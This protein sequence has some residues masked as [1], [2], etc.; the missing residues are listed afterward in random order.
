MK[1]GALIVGLIALASTVLLAIVH[2]GDRYFVLTTSGVWMGLAD[3]ARHGLIF[4]ADH[5]G[6][7]FAGTRY[8]PLPVLLHAGL[9]SLT[10]EYLTS[11]KLL[12]LLSLAVLCLLV[13]A[14]FRRSGLGLALT[15]GLLGAILVGTSRVHR[16]IVHQTRSGLGDT[17]AGRA[18]RGERRIRTPDD[19]FAGGPVLARV[20]GKAQCGLPDTR[21]R[22]LASDPGPPTPDRLR[23]CPRRL[24]GR[25][26]GVVHA[27]ER[28]THVH[29]ESDPARRRRDRGRAGCDG[30]DPTSS[31]ARRART[32]HVPVVAVRD[33]RDRTQRRGPNDGCVRVRAPVRDGHP[34]F[35]DGR[36]WL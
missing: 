23:R 33:R 5:G 28:R 29:E 35:P 21:D 3:Y 7:S 16:W 1:A 13:F 9:A 18:G 24:D 4:P 26:P 19:L 2:L 17:C 8:M 15:F 12:G 27:V 36:P 10:G 22:P 30:A 6:D 14:L 25:C 31:F 20:R 34:R 32:G 11:G